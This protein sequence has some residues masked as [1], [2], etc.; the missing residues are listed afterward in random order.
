M[1][2]CR[3]GLSLLSLNEQSPLL[4]VR[5]LTKHFA[6]GRKFGRT[7]GEII[8]AVCDV[9]LSI[10]TSKTLALVGETGC[11]KSTLA[12]TLLRIFEPTSGEAILRGEN[13]FEMSLRT[14]RSRRRLVQ[15]IFQDPYSSLNPR[16]SV[17]QLVSEAWSIHTEIVNADDRKDRSRELLEIVGLDVSLED[18]FVH[19]LSGGQRQRVAI[20]RALAVEPE[21]LVLDEPVSALDASIQAQV[22]NLLGE[23]QQ[24]MSIG[25]LFISHD[26]AAVSYLADAVAVMY[27]GRIVEQGPIAEVFEN[28]QHPYTRAL[29]S[30]HPNID[31]SQRGWQD[32]IILAGDMPS[33]ASP[34]S[35]C[36]FRTRCWKAQQICETVE[37]GLEESTPL[38][39]VACHFPE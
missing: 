38:R 18:R 12:R 1:P 17:S 3:G 30:A 15:L 2:S 37:P 4:D 13:I 24:R 32:R 29:L 31:P 9:D 16:R 39:R 35:G 26:L 33:P 25:Y 14:F 36:R 10:G 21:L 34:P 20:A 8:H 22:L 19:E 11:G 5:G 27:L 23:I 6:V 28:P 7:S